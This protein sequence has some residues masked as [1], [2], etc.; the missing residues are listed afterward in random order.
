MYFPDRPLRLIVQK[1]DGA[2]EHGVERIEITP[3]DV[4]VHIGAPYLLQYVMFFDMPHDSAS[5]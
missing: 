2:L 5:V 1:A 3:P 4:V